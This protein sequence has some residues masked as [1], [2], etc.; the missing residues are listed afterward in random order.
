[1]IFVLIIVVVLVFFVP[2]ASVVSRRIIIIIIVCKISFTQ[3]VSSPAISLKI[4]IRWTERA[5]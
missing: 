4:I 3:S 2:F 5:R 1:M